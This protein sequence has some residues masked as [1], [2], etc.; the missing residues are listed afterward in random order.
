M[1]DSAGLGNDSEAGGAGAGQGG[2][3]GT[4]VANSSGGSA[5]TSTGGSTAAGGGSTREECAWDP[6]AA[7]ACPVCASVRGCQRPGYKYVGSGAVTSSC[8]GLEWQEVTAPG[9]YTWS[10]A[11]EYCASLSLLGRGWRLPNAAELYSLV[12][13]S[14]E[15]PSPPTIDT[16]AFADT[17]PEAYWSSSHHGTGGQ[18]VWSVNF[19]DGVAR[20]VDLDARDQHR[21]R[22]VR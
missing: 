5:G 11:I 19:S 20:P 9:E 1:G 17:L 18:S 4:A 22:C 14:D 8:C 21:V 15:S 12:Y 10:E 3:G 7:D 2:G 16:Q 6:A 13:L